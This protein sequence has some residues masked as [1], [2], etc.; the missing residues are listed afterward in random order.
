MESTPA[1]SSGNAFW[2]S[3][4][5]KC[6]SKSLNHILSYCFKR[7]KL[8]QK[9]NSALSYGSEIYCLEVCK[10]LQPLPSE[11]RLKTEAV[12]KC[13]LF[14]KMNSFSHPCCSSLNLLQ[15]CY[16]VFQSQDQT[17]TQEAIHIAGQCKYGTPQIC[18]TGSGFCFVP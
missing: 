9:G 16:V 2:S 13:R 11:W 6:L 12:G 1:Q 3:V 14:L 8:T 4:Q 17:S 7:H 15:L 18:R 5:E 10:M